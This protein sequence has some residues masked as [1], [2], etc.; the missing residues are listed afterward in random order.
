MSLKK[1]IIKN[2]FVCLYWAK[3]QDNA[4]TVCH[5]TKMISIQVAEGELFFG[6]TFVFILYYPLSIVYDL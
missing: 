3:N 1:V 2:T 4:C 5:V 6:F